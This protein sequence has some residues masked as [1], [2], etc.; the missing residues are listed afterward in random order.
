[1]SVT[2]LIAA[3]SAGFGSIGIYRMR[4]RNRIDTFY[5]AYKLACTYSFMRRD[6]SYLSVTACT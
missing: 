6:D 2:I 5:S 4:Q 1:M 3:V